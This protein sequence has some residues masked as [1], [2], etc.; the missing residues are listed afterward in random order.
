VSIRATV[1]EDPWRPFPAGR[2]SN[3]CWRHRPQGRSS[4]PENNFGLG[5]S[6][7]LARCC[8]PPVGTRLPE[9]DWLRRPDPAIDRSEPQWTG[10]GRRYPGCCSYCNLQARTSE[11]RKR[12]L[13][14]PRKDLGS[15]ARHSPRIPP[16]EPWTAPLRR[17][18]E[19]FFT[20]GLRS[21]NSQRSWEHCLYRK[22]P[23][24]D[25]QLQVPRFLWNP[26]DA[27]HTLFTIQTIKQIITMVPSIPYPN[28]VSS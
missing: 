21:T 16:S 17:W 4:G 15:R 1:G 22:E 8:W 25:H 7:A 27:G 6:S 2:S 19:V 18:F 23:I 28:I 11:R 3:R 9:P 20:C 14:Q 13:G 5:S 10:F 26:F 12:L 24:H